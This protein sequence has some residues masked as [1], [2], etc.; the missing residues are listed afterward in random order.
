[1]VKILCSQCRVT[2]LI[3]GQGTKILHAA[4]CSQPPPQKKLK[5]ITCLPE[6]KI[7]LG[8]LYLNLINLAT[9]GKA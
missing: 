9:L 7:S 4:R 1:M 8:V 6:I 3:P 2:G 5:R